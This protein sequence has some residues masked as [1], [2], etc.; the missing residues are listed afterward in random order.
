MADAELVELVESAP[1]ETSLDHDDL[2]NA[3]VVWL[4][5]IQGA[6][7]SLD[8]AQFYVIDRP[9]S[10]L[11][12]ILAAVEAAAAR[13]VRVRVL[14]DARFAKTYPETLDLFASRPVIQVRRFDVGASMGG[15]LHAKYFLVDGREAYVGSQNFDRRSLEHIQELGAR[16]RV[17]DVVRAFSD[18]FE[19]DWALAGGA[20]ATT[21]LHRV[22]ARDEA[23]VA[24]AGARLSSVSPV[25][26][27]KD[28]LPDEELWDLP[29]LVDLIGSAKK[30]V[31]VQLLTYRASDR[32]GGKF[33]D[34][35]RA[36]R[37]AAAR[38]VRVELLVSDWCKRKG[39]IE[40]L[41]AL[42]RDGGV[43]V[44]LVTI[45]AWSGGFV[46]YAR[47]IHA[48]YLVVDGERAWLGTS[49][50]ER[51]YFFRSRNLGLVIE[52]AKLSG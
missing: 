3:D 2:R 15:V 31:R 52:S 1:I 17:P 33:E 12:P 8:V 50:W 23:D 36:L 21:R 29:R 10:R 5:M 30:S 11:E 45:P 18:V 46:P 51:D 4:E 34:L 26:S 25:A 38:G 39:T 42:Q 48:K 40:G 43:H 7:R 16:V 32:D 35:D 20:P 44:R 41:Q 13:G 47:T 14:A 24:E 37:A 6:E 27:P 19:T 9:G 49:N 22:D 28:W